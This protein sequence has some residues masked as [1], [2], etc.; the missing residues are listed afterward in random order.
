VTARL[1]S[2]RGSRLVLA[3]ALAATAVV[4]TGV[5]SVLL[6]IAAALVACDS[7]L[8]P[9]AGT[10]SEAD[11]RVRAVVRARRI[12]EQRRRMRGL[13]PERLALLDDR[14]GWAAVAEHRDRGIQPVEVA[15]IVGTVEAAKAD[16]FDARFRPRGS[17]AEHWK[18]LW[19]AVAHGASLPP[20]SVYRVGDVHYVRD[21]H[22][23]VSVARD[24][25]HTTIDAEVTELRRRPERGL[26]PS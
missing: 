22:H 9:P 26:A 18:R 1:G 3:A 4:A 12:A 14:H 23:R 13:A 10:W 7:L 20:I 8:P 15:S 6:W 25:G 17:D 21:G 5:A 2:R 19:L 11:D 16:I 24:H